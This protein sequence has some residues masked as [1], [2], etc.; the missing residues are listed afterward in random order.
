MGTT[1]TAEVTNQIQ[2]Y[3]A[4]IFTRKLREN[5]LLGQFVNKDY[6]GQIK[7]GGDTVYVSQL[8]DPTGQLLTV[9]VDAGTFAA[10][11]A[12]T[13]RVGITANKRAV[14]AY[15]FEDLVELQSQID[16][17]TMQEACIYSL[18]Q[19]IND[20][21][22][23]LVSPSTSSPDHSVSGV[24]DFNKTQLVA[25]RTLA[26]A[27][28]WS[29]ERGWF[30]MLDPSYWGDTLSD[31]TLTSSDYVDDM[32]IVQGQKARRLLGFNAYE[33]NSRSTDYGLAFHPDFLHLVMQTEVQVKVSDLHSNKQFGA[34]L[35]VDLIFGA[36]LGIEGNKKHI[37][38]YNA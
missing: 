5:L 6:E 18:N 32:P 11:K 35:S 25:V 27:A 26:S 2:K 19:Q 36:G 16:R 4:P 12:S 20:Y 23:S 7:K 28:K 37:K 21:L 13:T 31:S 9:G 17:P 29:T 10:E 30:L 38:I 15:E 8:N 1:T 3:W 34:L 33:D 22:Y 14:A 24:T